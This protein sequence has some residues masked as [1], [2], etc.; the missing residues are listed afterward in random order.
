MA[1][2]SFQVD[3]PGS[4]GISPRIIRLKTDDN[5]TTIETAN[6]LEELI[7][8]GFRFKNSDVFFI[9]YGTD[10]NSFDIYTITIS[11]NTTTLVPYV[12]TDATLPV[13]DNH[14]ALFDGTSGKIKDGPIASDITKTTLA[15]IN[16]TIVANTLP[17]YSDA[18]GTIENSTISKLR[19]LQSGFDS[20]SPSA[21][22]LVANVTVDFSD[23]SGGGSKVLVSSS[24]SQTYI[25]LE[26]YLNSGG[27]DFSGGG[28][29]RNAEI[30]DG[31]NSWSIIPA[32]TLQALINAR[33]GDTAVAF[34]ASVNINTVTQAGDDLVLQYNGG[35]TDYTA[36]SLIITV[37]AQRIS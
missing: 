29:D 33:W 21:N 2:L 15:A 22:I 1:I 27:T 14:I 26:V 30:T 13:T 18:N 8:Q 20:P 4:I 31:T 6:Y 25:V 7:D 12:T 35:T 3:L 19:V 37:V 11:G 16:G 34:P 17:S 36:G 5:T 24:G 10:S 32:A 28:G 23:M 9:N